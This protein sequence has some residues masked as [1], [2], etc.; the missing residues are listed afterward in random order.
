[1]MKNDIINKYSIIEKIKDIAYGELYKIDY[2]TSTGKIPA[3]LKIINYYSVSDVEVRDALFREVEAISKI[4]NNPYI[5]KYY[6][7]FDD[8][9][10]GKLYII[11]EYLE[12]LGVSF[13]G[14]HYTE[15]N[16]IEI[17][18]NIL[19]ALAAFHVNDIIHNNINVDN[20][21]VDGTTYKLG[22]IDALA[23]INNS[24]ST[25]TDISLVGILLY[26][27]LAGKLPFDL[28]SSDEVLEMLKTGQ[29]VPYLE[30]ISADLMNIIMLALDIDSSEQYSDV[31]K[32]YDALNSINIIEEQ[33]IVDSK[34]KV[35][36]SSDTLDFDSPVANCKLYDNLVSIR[37]K[38]SI[39]DIFKILSWI[40]FGVVLVGGILFLWR[41]KF[42]CSDGKINK[43]GICVEGHYECPDGYDLNGSKCQKIV[44]KVAATEN[45]YC[46]EDY[47]YSN[48]LCVYKKS[49]K[50]KKTYM[51]ADDFKLDGKKCIQEM[52]AEAP[53][54]YTCPDN[55]VLAGTICVTINSFDASKSYTCPDSSYTK[56]GTVCTKTNQSITNAVTTYGCS[57]GGSF[58]NSGCYLTQNPSYDQY[59]N[60]ICPNGYLYSA[61]DGNCGLYYQPT[62]TYSCLVGTSDGQGH[63][64]KDINVS[65]PA[66]ANYTCPDGYTKVGDKCTNSATI[67]ANVKYVCTDEME[68]K[69]G[70]CHGKVTTDALELYTCPDGY[71]L[72]GV[73]CLKDDFKE[74]EVKYTCSRV[75][76][77]KND[78]CV[79]YKKINAKP[80]YD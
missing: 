5:I 53:V 63:C 8:S 38:Y 3:Y 21:Y 62:P 2:L 41:M 60:P 76:Q 78:V 6:D 43:Y 59:N 29:K 45:V 4:Q 26:Q 47:I 39:K 11:F 68:L 19:L 69:D 75:Y 35:K 17:G 67:D 14:S 23:S 64:V 65:V 50:P 40:V 70:V 15:K 54:V 77:L 27:L 56:S 36:K 51:C 42:K 74:P 55:Y 22:G 72:S 73:T 28:K 34:G 71:I 7:V 18:K 52:N 30:N 46:P 80:I 20:I 79:K 61:A 1:M 33:P 13:T 32:M 58:T 31:G 10:D 48:D 9:E 66:I 49:K 25:K 16:I 44:K 24:F 37:K 12:S 57:R